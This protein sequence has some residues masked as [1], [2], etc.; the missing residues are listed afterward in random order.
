M[1]IYSVG[2]VNPVMLTILYVLQCV[3]NSFYVGITGSLA[4]RLSEHSYGIKGK[5]FRKKTLHP[6]R[7]I[8]SCIFSSW[9]D[10]MKKEVY[11]KRLNRMRLIKELKLS[12]QA[13]EA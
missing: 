6:F 8:Y 7:L 12:C 10:A 9:F 13:G 3:D 11:F 4:R 5:W 2:V 1:A